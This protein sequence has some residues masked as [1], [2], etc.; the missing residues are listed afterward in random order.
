MGRGL[1][2]VAPAKINLALH[3]TGR[4]DDGYHLLET[5]AAFTRFG[6]RLRVE[7]TGKDGFDVSGPFHRQ[8][9]RDRDNLVLHARDLM[10]QSFAGAARRP[11]KLHLEKNLPVASGIG[12]GSSDAATAL[13]LL[14]RYWNLE[15]GSDA[16]AKIALRLGADVPMCLAARPLSARGI[17]D[18]IDVL[19]RF[20]ELPLLLVNPG[21]PLATP[22][23]FR[24]LLQREN[25]SLPRL[26]CTGVEA[27]VDWLARTRNDLE[28]PALALMPAIGGV[29][30]ALRKEGALIAR[31]S[32]SGAT[33][34][35]VFETM[36]TADRA[37]TAI[38]GQHPGWFVKA[39][40][41]MPAAEEAFSG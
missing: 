25:P 40:S 9:P 12:G 16:L 38:S 2:S 28:A 18:G 24:A 6:D 7:E 37:E 10:R 14:S 39:T 33:C 15:T 1:E 29:V 35:G 23:V 34:F 5:L 11:V 3:V 13:K 36:H 17:G 26:D 31:M 30:H 22:D 19:P 32:G 20:P 4:R 8:V 27:V 21:A 41:T